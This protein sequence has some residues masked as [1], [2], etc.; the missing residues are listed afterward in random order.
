MLVRPRSSRIYYNKQFFS[1]PLNFTEV[2]KKLGL[3]KSLACFFSYLKAKI[4]P[5]KDPH[6]FEEWVVNHFGNYLFTLFFKTY[7]EKVWGM[8]CKEISADW[9]AQRI[10]GLSLAKAIL[11]SL[12]PRYLRKTKTIKSLIET[13]RY[14]RKGPGMLWETCASK[15]VQMGGHIEMGKKITRIEYRPHAEM[16]WETFFNTPEGVS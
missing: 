11:N 16:P 14:P 15:L 8:S 2:L 5:H 13:F 9:A 3:M 4:N 10:K 1:Y 12:K 6:S 7:T